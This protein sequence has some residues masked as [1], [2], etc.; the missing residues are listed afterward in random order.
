MAIVKHTHTAPG[1][2]KINKYNILPIVVIRHPVAWLQSMCAN[3]Y[4]AHWKHEH[5]H[6]PNFVPNDVDRKK[7]PMIQTF[8]VTINFDQTDHVTFDSLIHL[9]NQWYRQ[10]LQSSDPVLIG[11]YAMYCHCRTFLQ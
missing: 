9:W 7:F 6:C 8:P 3:P 1:M 11:T 10:Y 5:N 4:A 2:E